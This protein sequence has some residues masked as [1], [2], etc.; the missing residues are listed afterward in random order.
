V[1]PET[2]V[3]AADGTRCKVVLTDLPASHPSWVLEP[4]AV[5][6]AEAAAA[7]LVPV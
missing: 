4:L 1:D 7:E 2:V 3:I 6:E 5:P